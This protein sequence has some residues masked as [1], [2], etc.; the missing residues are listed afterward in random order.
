LQSFKNALV[1]ARW[2]L[3]PVIA[4]AASYI[5]LVSASLLRGTFYWVLFPIAAVLLLL[6]CV[7]LA[8][9]H[10]RIVAISV[11]LAGAVFAVQYLPYPNVGLHFGYW[12]YP[13]RA[14]SAFRSCPNVQSAQLVGWNQDVTLEEF[15]IRVSFSDPNGVLVTQGISFRQYPTR[16]Y[17]AARVAT[18]GCK[19]V[20]ARK[21][22]SSEKRR[23]VASVGRQVVA[24][25]RVRHKVLGRFPATKGFSGSS[26]RQSTGLHMNE[27]SLVTRAIL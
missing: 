13:N 8:P 6:I 26:P 5:A 18:I 4:L 12:R 25:V 22:P 19:A 23:L 17:I 20:I 1:F 16:E 3:I 14:I 24:G 2:A 15:Q 27:R 10:K 9:T 7:R 21:A 11:L